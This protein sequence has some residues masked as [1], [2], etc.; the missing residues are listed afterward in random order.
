M[1]PDIATWSSLA[2]SGVLR[3]DAWWVVTPLEGPQVN[4][5]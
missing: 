1:A 2:H 5:L 3:T 4:A